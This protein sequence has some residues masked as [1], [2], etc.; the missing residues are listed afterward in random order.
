MS[1]MQSLKVMQ[2]ITQAVPVVKKKVKVALV[3]K[4]C[5]HFRGLI[6]LERII[7]IQ[8]VRKARL[9]GIFYFQIIVS[10]LLSWFTFL[11][12]QPLTFLKKINK[13]KKIESKKY[14]LNT[15]MKSKDS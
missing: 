11:E 10:R 9:F 3:E 14:F 8:S 7:T 13:N 2:F 12:L 1:C 5:T 6:I 4:H 15:F